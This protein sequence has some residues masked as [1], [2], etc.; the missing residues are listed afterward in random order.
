MIAAI[1][2]VE[3]F[4]WTTKNVKGSSAGR[5]WSDIDANRRAFLGLT[6]FKVSMRN[7]VRFWEDTLVDPLPLSIS[8]LEFY[9][10]SSIKGKSIADC[11]RSEVLT[12]DLSLRRN[13]FDRELDRWSSFTE[14]LD[15]VVLGQGRDVLWWKADRSRVFSEKSAFLVLTTL[16]PRMQSSTSNL[17]WNFRVP[18][19]VKVFMWFLFYRGINTADK[20]Q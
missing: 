14:K 15:G 16:S 5:P 20:L 18:K 6:F 3:A 2:G 12:W 1:Y 11:W 19:K 7:R 8:F 9:A 4:W 17:I 13:L 10:L